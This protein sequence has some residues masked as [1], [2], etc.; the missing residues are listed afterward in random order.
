MW[1]RVLYNKPYSNTFFCPIY[2]LA[3][4]RPTTLFHQIVIMT[5]VITFYLCI[6]LTVLTGIYSLNNVVMNKRIILNRS[7]RFFNRNCNTILKLS[8]PSENEVND[9]KQSEKTAGDKIS[10]WEKEIV[11]NPLTHIKRNK[12]AVSH[13]SHIS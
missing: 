7:S 5:N 11:D 13:L 8:P 9:N 12:F 6:C 2:W 1:C 10:Q 3:N 4:S